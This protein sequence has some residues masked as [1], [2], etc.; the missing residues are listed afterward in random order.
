MMSTAILLAGGSGTR[1][2]SA[3]PKQFL[4]IS[5]KEIWART[6]QAFQ[7]CTQIGKIILVCREDYFEHMRRGVSRHEFSKVTRIVAGG[8]DSFHSAL[9]GLRASGGAASDKVLILG[10]GR[11]CIPVAVIQRALAMLD[12]YESCDTGIPVV[13]TLFEAE[14]DTIASIPDR[15]RFYSG[16]GPEGFHFETVFSAL[17]RHV[18]DGE[19]L[20]TNIS[21][22]VRRY[23]PDVEMGLAAGSEVNIKITTPKDLLIAEQLLK[24]APETDRNMA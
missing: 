7:D 20:M 12:A 16:Q 8:R 3:I 24:L 22:I 18:R 13:E 6:V 21:G 14:G 17:S 11:P 2:E 5:G 10:E 9:N 23:F 19:G 15:A 4:E 1:M